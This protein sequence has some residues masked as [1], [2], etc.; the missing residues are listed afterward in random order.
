MRLLT[1]SAN[2]NP[3]PSK[4]TLSIAGTPEELRELQRLRY[5]AR[6]S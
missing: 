3:S 2:A 6:P 4:L 1:T 5:E